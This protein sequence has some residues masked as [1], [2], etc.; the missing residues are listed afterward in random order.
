[1][2]YHILDNFFCGDSWPDSTEPKD[3]VGS[4]STEP[5][6]GTGVLAERQ[7]D[8]AFSIF[9]VCTGFEE[10]TLYERLIILLY[11]YCT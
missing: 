4:P 5:K 2:G 11:T 7:I 9:F 10:Y 1:M 3:K 8:P 6:H